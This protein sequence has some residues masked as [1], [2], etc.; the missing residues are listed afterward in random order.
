[1]RRHRGDGYGKDDVMINPLRKASSRGQWD[2][3]KKLE[4]V[5]H[6]LSQDLESL[7]QG[8]ISK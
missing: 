5:F 2:Y 3:P 6:Y 8:P 1:M 4:R 7:T